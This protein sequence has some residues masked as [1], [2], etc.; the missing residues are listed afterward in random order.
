V[1][2]V[3]WTRT[4]PDDIEQV[5]AVLVCR[6]FPSAIRVRPSQGD[7]GIDILVPIENGCEVYQVKSFTQTLTAKQKKQIQ[8][9][10]GRIVV[11]ASQNGLVVTT[12]HITLPLDPTKE[13]L[14]WL[15]EIAQKVGLKADWRGLIFCDE[16]AK[17][18]G[19]TR[20]WG[21]LKAR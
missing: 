4:A 13:N 7:G 5:L 9:S 21:R 6:E 16:S 3:E 14:R 8:R 2:R 10:L 17:L 11:Y 1:A 19:A 15:S 18:W 12:W 20:G